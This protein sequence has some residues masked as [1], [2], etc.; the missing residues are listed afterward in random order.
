MQPFPEK[1]NN[2]SLVGI[3]STYYYNAEKDMKSYKNFQIS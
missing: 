2:L 1:I 3:V